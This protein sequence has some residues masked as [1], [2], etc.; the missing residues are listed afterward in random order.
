MTGGDVPL[1][2][3]GALRIPPRAA[4][5]AE[6]I[7]P[8]SIVIG[9]FSLAV[10]FGVAAAIVY[11]VVRY[12]SGRDVDRSGAPRGSLRLEIAWTIIPI[13]IAFGLFAWSS[14][15]FLRV[16]RP[17]R[18]FDGATIWVVGKQWMWKFSHESGREEIDTL[19]LPVGQDIR[20]ALTSQDVIHSLYL[21]AFRLKQDVLPGRYTTMWF[22]ATRPG[23][24]HL[25]CAEYCGEE[26][27]RMRGR[28]IVM[29]PGEYERWAA[30]Q[31]RDPGAAP[32]IGPAGGPDSP[33]AIPERPEA[34]DYPGAGA[35]WRFGCVACHLP[36]S[37]QR[38]PRLDGLWGQEIRLEGGAHIVADENYIRESILV[39]DARIAAG[40]PSPSLMPAYA[41]QVTEEDMRE[42]IRFIQS[43][44]HGWPP[45]LLPGEG[46]GP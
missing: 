8:V 39:P 12:H 46:E 34:S 29:A 19:H 6:M 30:G 38:A 14:A 7:D 40:Y 37:P 18:N 11:F 17:P 26:H 5:A 21:P 45:E 3:P 31:P 22:R 41:G 16:Q 44:E 9:L 42:L 4:T 25:F 28:L 33:L 24:Y 15:V 23:E 20:L 13:L 43:L 32:E 36:T 1:A 2:A 10:S 35:F 27:S